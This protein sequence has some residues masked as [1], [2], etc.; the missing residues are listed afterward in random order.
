MNGEA[1][2]DVRVLHEAWAYFREAAERARLAVEETE[3]FRGRAD[4]R[5]SAYHGLLEAH[6]MAYDMAVAPRMDHPVINTRAWFHNSHTLGGTSGDLYHVCA[7]VD[8]RHSYRLSGRVGGMKILVMQIFNTIL[9]GAG[10]RQVTHAD[11]AAMAGADG[12]FEVILSATPRDGHWL[13]LDEQSRCNFVFIRRFHDD[14]YVD[15]GELDIELLDGPV[16]NGDTDAAAMAGRIRRAAD[17]MTFLVKVWNIDI[18]DL[19][20]RKNDGRK[21]RLAVV[22]GSEIAADAAG[23][24]NTIYSWGVFDIQED[25]ALLIECDAPR[26]GFWSYQIQNVWTKPI[27]YL[28]HQSEINQRL[29]AIDA[30]GKFRA[31]ICLKDPGIANWLDPDGHREGTIVGR[32]YHAA[33]RPEQPVVRLIKAAALEAYLPP[34][35]KRTTPAARRRAM[36]LRRKGLLRMFGDL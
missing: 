19:Y 5:A 36:Q 16:D 35:T 4:H 1:D 14:W 6:S 7:V 34:G 8:G 31:V 26:A 20:L 29:A 24:P 21:N 30:D 22:P 28:D 33:T 9:G 13:A 32:A 23:S 25:E 10:Q 3:R 15:R 27:N 12:R 18:Y 11:L 2:G 17:L